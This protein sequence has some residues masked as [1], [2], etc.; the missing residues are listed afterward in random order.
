M[1]S[2]FS[3]S[4]GT[5]G[6]LISM[7]HNG[8]KIPTSIAKNMVQ[9]SLNVV[10]TDWYIDKLY[11][12]ATEMGI[13]TLTPKY[14]RYVI[15][16]NRN[17]NG[18][19]LYAGADNTE[20]CPTTAFD[21]SPLYLENKTPSPQEIANRIEHYWHPYHNAI[22]NTLAEL[23]QQHGKVVLL[24]AHS[25]LS[26]VP[27]FFEG[28]LPDFN[29]GSADGLSCDKTLIEHIKN[30]NFNPYTSVYDGRFKGGYITRTY[31]DPINDIHAI[32]L[33]LSQDT[34]MDETSYSY[35]ESKAKQVKL[36]LKAVVE[37]LANFSQH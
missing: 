11:D 23:K 29:F 37:C 28:K 17:P 10:D 20:L 1:N 19:V 24:D 25:I 18:E 9:N 22:K 2:T 3:L 31:G 7:P 4:S 34:Y 26:R 21:S 35:N 36:K 30:I 5:I 27:R 13:H 15:D 32:Q 8:Q 6:M 33:E 16:L 14:N 12:F